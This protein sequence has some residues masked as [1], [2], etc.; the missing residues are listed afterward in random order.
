MLTYKQSITNLPTYNDGVFK[1]FQIE[2][3]EETYPMEY[4]KD[5]G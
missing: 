4:I 5:T 2:Q 3:T 1:L